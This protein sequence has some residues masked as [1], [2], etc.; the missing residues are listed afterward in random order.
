M[1]A[2]FLSHFCW[3]YRGSCGPFF[4]SSVILVLLWGLLLPLLPRLRLA[5]CQLLLHLAHCH[6]LLLD[7]GLLVADG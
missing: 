7:L 6:R 2:G 3:Y 5:H 1:L 4:V